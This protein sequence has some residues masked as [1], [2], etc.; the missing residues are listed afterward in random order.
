MEEPW[1][2]ASAAPSRSSRF[3]SPVWN[4]KPLGSRKLPSKNAGVKGNRPRW[5]ISLNFKIYMS[6]IHARG[7]SIHILKH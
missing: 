1:R 3:D 4:R 6:V 2:V 5:L 7:L